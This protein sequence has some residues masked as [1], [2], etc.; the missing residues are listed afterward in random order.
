VQIKV[1]KYDVS[2]SAPPE[3]EF[4]AYADLVGSVTD[5]ESLGN[6]VR[7]VIAKQSPE[8]EA[9]VLREQACALLAKADALSPKA[10]TP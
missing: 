4:Y 2:S 10:S 8:M 1:V 7:L 9:E 5:K 3:S 6:A